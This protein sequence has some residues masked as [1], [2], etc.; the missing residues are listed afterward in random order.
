MK[1]KINLFLI[2]LIIFELFP[3]ASFAHQQVVH[4]AITTNAATA[5]SAVSFDYNDFLNTIS[6]DVPAASAN[7]WMQIG[8]FDEDN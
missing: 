8:S 6:S 2:L 4:E 1:V 3:C 5:A 7:D